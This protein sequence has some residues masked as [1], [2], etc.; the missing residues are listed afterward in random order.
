[1]PGY[2]HTVSSRISLPPK[3]D[4]VDPLTISRLLESASVSSAR[5]LLTECLAIPGATI[6]ERFGGDVVRVPN[7]GNPM[8]GLYLMTPNVSAEYLPA[9][10][11]TSYHYAQSICCNGLIRSGS[12]TQAYLAPLSGSRTTEMRFIAYARDAVARNFYDA[13]STMYEQNL[14]TRSLT[15]EQLTA[16]L[17]DAISK[18]ATGGRVIFGS[19]A[20]IPGNLAADVSLMGQNLEFLLPLSEVTDNSNGA[21][22]QGTFRGYEASAPYVSPEHI[23]YQSPPFSP[24]QERNLM[25]GRFADIF[26]AHDSHFR[27][28]LAEGLRDSGA[29]ERYLHDQFN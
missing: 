22:K 11:S 8:L 14:Q 3:G 4:V 2:D 18:T 9:I 21:V 28:A 7:P 29:G 10:H 23:A 15:D 24:F 20:R 19:M 5:D 12:S 17:I 1:M 16:I 6:I 25:S 26:R 27:F 13:L